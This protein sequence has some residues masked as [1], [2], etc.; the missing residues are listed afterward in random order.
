MIMV[1]KLTNEQY[2]ALEGQIYDDAG[3]TYNPVLDGD[4][5]YIITEVEVEKTTNPEFLW[6]KNLPLTQYKAPE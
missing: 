3:T 4:G 5:D 6:L 2:E 1:A